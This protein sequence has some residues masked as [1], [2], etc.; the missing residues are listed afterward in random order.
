MRRRRS[1]LSWPGAHRRCVRAAGADLV[2]VYIFGDHIPHMH[3]HLAPHVEGD[4][5]NGSMIKGELEERALPS[6]AEALISKD[7]PEIDQD[8]LRAVV[9]RRS[10]NCSAAEPPSRADRERQ[11]WCVALG[12][13]GID[14]LPR[15]AE[16]FTELT[17]R[18]APARPI[19][20]DA[21]A[22]AVKL[23]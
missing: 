2:Y 10:A 3:A 9:Q 5:L 1:G 19:I 12:L 23:T 13:D 22:H 18:Q 6:G 11:R 20:P 7:Y 16:R 4:A 21:V 8:R 14:G 17:L 15:D